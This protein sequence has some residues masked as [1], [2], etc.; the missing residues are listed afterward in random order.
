VR[1]F[2]LHKTEST[3][4][5]LQYQFFNKIAIILFKT[6]LGYF[7]MLSAIKNRV[8][9]IFQLI[10]VIIYILFEELIWE[11]IAKPVYE[12][13]HALKILQKVEL[14]LQ[15]V[16][17]TVVIFFFMILLGL[18]E[19]LGIYAGVLFVSGQV[20]LGLLLYISKIPIAAFTFWMFRVTEDKLM[21]FG[22]FKWLYELMMNG[23]EWLK[24]REIYQKT[25]A[26]LAQVKEDLKKYIKAIKERY[27]SKET[28]FV[29]RVKKLYKRV[30]ESLAE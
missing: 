8:I 1:H 22:W 2:F 15:K 18:V 16:S 27:F 14:K 21:Q 25:M 19:T 12:A 29:R 5:L 9:S 23:I 13:L 11:G 7:T 26:R 4:S 20:L 30:K 6:D 3:K 24:S 28:P 17:A 10:L